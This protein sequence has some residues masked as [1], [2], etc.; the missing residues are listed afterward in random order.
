M[1]HTFGPSV[2]EGDEEAMDH[3]RRADIYTIEDEAVF[4]DTQL[5]RGRYDFLFMEA[6]SF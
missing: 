4:K 2:D 3:G 1:R 6:V 5:F